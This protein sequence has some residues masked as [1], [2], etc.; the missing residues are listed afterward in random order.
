MPTPTTPQRERQR[1]QRQSPRTSRPRG[2][3]RSTTAGA[4]RPQ[5]HGAPG[6]RGTR[7]RRSTRPATSRAARARRPPPPRPARATRRRRRRASSGPAPRRRP[8]AAARLRS[9]LARSP[10][11]RLAFDLPGQSGSLCARRRPRSLALRHPAPRA[12]QVG[13][14]SGREGYPPTS[15]P[16]ARARYPRAPWRT[17]G[18]RR[19]ST[20]AR[21]PPPTRSR[22]RGSEDGKGES[23][24]DRFSHTPGRV[25]DGD[26]GDVA[27]DSYHRFDEDVA[28][29]REMNLTSYR[30]SIAWPRIQPDG[31]RR[32]EPEGPRLLPAPGGR[33]AGRRA[34]DRFPTLYHW[35]LPQALEDAGGWTARDTAGRFADYAEI[36]VRA[37]G[38]RVSDWM[39]LNEPSV[40]LAMGY[41][42]GRPRARAGAG[43]DTWL[44][45]SHVV[46][47]AQARAFQAMRAAAGGARIGSAFAFSPCVPMRRHGGGSRPPPSAGTASRTPGSSIRPSAGGYPAVHA[48]GLPARAMG[49]RDGRR[50]APARAPRLHRHQPLHAGRR[51]GPRG[52]SL[53]VGALP[54]RPMGLDQG[55][56]T[57]AGWEVWPDA[58]Y[59]MLMRLTRDYDRPVLEITENGCSYADGPDERRRDRRRPAGRL[60]ARATW[61]PR[62]GR[63]ATVPTCAATTPGACS[64]TSSGTQG[65]ARALRPVLGRLRHRRA[66]PEATPRASTPASPTA[67]AS[68][69][70]PRAPRSEGEIRCRTSC[71]S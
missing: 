3:R 28:L 64:T 65:Y 69:P 2:S 8:A 29:L 44:P 47:L 68:S 17:S 7:T 27:C 58:L 50:R 15:G 55:P 1:Q 59:D 35:D 38:D 14:V 36:V 20:G 16:A 32:G 33:P 43:L 67:T 61:R 52:R 71:S 30:F 70:E 4:G 22:A 34:S 11:A 45:A 66:H 19:A 25:K 49:I 46:N 51:P 23:I 18:F 53:R 21:P 9:A 31:T 12:P 60:S 10:P 39:I 13:A 63:S 41:L 62:P 40:F 5:R 54:V 48:D 37:L 56:Q 42:A 24:W 6:S 57:D 26:T